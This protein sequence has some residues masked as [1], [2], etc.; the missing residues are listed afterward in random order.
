MFQKLYYF[1]IAMTVILIVPI[2]M[3]CI[4]KTEKRIEEYAVMPNKYL[5]LYGVDIKKMLN[6]KFFEIEKEI[7]KKT[8][9]D[10]EVEI[11]FIRKESDLVIKKQ[12]TEAK[13]DI[14][15][16]YGPIKELHDYERYND[17]MPHTII[18]NGY[19][20]KSESADIKE[21]IVKELQ[22]NLPKDDTTTQILEKIRNEFIDK[23]DTN[24][25]LTINFKMSDFPIANF[26]IGVFQSEIFYKYT[27]SKKKEIYP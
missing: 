18:F 20:K 4:N 9:I 17:I 3:S 23:N 26:H 11:V 25:T 12:P 8:E 5:I 13:D 14:E 15:I 6:K 10:K 19:L 21:T 16:S 27:F 24:S 22:K 2:F 1:I 7:D